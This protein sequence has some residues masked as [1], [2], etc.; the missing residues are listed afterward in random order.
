M[1]TPGSLGAASPLTAALLVYDAR[2]RLLDATPAAVRLLGGPAGPA[3]GEG[4]DF[5]SDDADEL[6][7]GHPVLR[8][9]EAR[10]PARARLL[11]PGGH[12]PLLV[13]AA[14]VAIAS[15]R[16]LVV[17]SLSRPAGPPVPEPFG[18]AGLGLPEL[19]GELAQSRLDRLSLL[20]RITQAVSGACSRTAVVVLMDRDPRTSHVVTADALDPAVAGQIDRYVADM[21]RPGQAP[22][23]GISELVISSGEAV[24]LP[25]ISYAD[26]VGRLSEKATMLYEQAAPVDAAG[27]RPFSLLIVPI[28]SRGSILGT[29]G[30]V[31]LRGGPRLTAADQDWLQA[32]A[33]RTAIL[34]D[35]LQLAEVAADRLERLNCMRGITAAIADGQSLPAV[36]TLILKHVTEVLDIDAADILVTRTEDTFAVTAAAGFADGGV[37]DYRFPIPE[38]F[39]RLAEQGREAVTS[40]MKALGYEERQ[41]LFAREGFRSYLAMP[42]VSSRQAVGTLELFQRQDWTATPDALEFL[43][44]MAD[45]AAIAIS[46]AGIKP[47]AGGGARGTGRPLTPVEEQILAGVAGGLTNRAIAARLQLADSNVKFH[48]RQILR[49]TGAANRAQLVHRASQEGWLS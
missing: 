12:P 18:W 43:A 23:T 32:V 30:L 31:D 41:P 13:E 6:P 17:A 24:L 45:Q 36:L 16:P 22:T 47:A 15:G 44:A 42:V 8:A 19:D 14:P 2:G 11:R 39:R 27:D 26:F 33:D 21:G 20:R 34:L 40:D 49:K 35:T 37:P 25:S 10:A 1:S 4:W 7:T 48:L 5:R 38:P 9:I 3:G 46:A 28:R 29:L